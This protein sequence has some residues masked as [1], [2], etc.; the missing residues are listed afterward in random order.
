VPYQIDR[1][2]IANALAQLAVRFKEARSQYI[3]AAKHD[4]ERLLQ[5]IDVEVAF[6]SEG[7]G[8]VVS[9]GIGLQFI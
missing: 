9:G 7:P 8:Q 5:G 1:Y 4:T 3:M 6:Y 2:V